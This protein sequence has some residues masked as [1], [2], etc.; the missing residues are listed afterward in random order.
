VYVAASVEGEEPTDEEDVPDTP[1]H[2]TDSDSTSD[3][4]DTDDDNDKVHTT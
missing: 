3:D 2:D 4:Q 1:K